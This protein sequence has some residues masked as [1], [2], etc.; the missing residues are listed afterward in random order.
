MTNAGASTA[1]SYLLTISAR[2]NRHWEQ[3]L[4]NSAADTKNNSFNSFII[5]HQLYQKH[6]LCSDLR[7]YLREN[8]SLNIW[9]GI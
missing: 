4:I 3:S 1:M 2:E 6:T 5:V 7:Q 9:P 8:E